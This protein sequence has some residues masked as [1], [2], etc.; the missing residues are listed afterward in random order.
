MLKKE[1]GGQISPTVTSQKHRLQHTMKIK[2][3]EMYNLLFPI[4]PS[5]KAISFDLCLVIFII[6][7]RRLALPIK[8]TIVW[9]TSRGR[10]F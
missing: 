3:I 9:Q 1:K 4:S 8:L 6:E 2:N 5:A 10:H 7:F